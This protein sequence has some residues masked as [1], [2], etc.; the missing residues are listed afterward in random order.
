MAIPPPSRI[1]SVALDAFDTFT[2]RLPL[3]KLGP[4]VSQ[5]VFTVLPL[6]SKCP[7]RVASILRYI[8]IDNGA[9]YVLCLF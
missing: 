4:L 2:R 9:A 1:V 7:D 5:I 8:V 3:K 6:L